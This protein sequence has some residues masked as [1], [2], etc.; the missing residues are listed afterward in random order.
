MTKKPSTASRDSAKEDAKRIRNK[1]RGKN[2]DTAD[3]AAVKPE[4]L[5]QLV[6]AVTSRECA[7]QFGYT[8]DGG[9]YCLRIVGDGEPYNEY[10]RPTEDVENYLQGMIEDFQS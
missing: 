10:V 1:N 3:Y 4:I 6:A 9:A 8:R 7:I 2:G 5:A